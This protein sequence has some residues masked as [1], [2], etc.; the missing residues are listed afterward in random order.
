MKSRESDI[1]R[2]LLQLARLN[3]GRLTDEAITDRL[4][5]S[6]SVAS[7]L[8]N[9]LKKGIAKIGVQ[10]NKQV[11]LFADLE[12]E[13]ILNVCPSCGNYYPVRDEIEQ[14]PVCGS[15]VKM[16]RSALAKAG[17]SKTIDGED[18]TGVS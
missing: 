6:D 2:E 11:Y 17:K 7:E 8:A 18:D 12:A 5:K 9:L 4:G 1:R 3:G 13:L 15:D 16:H 10:D 14:C